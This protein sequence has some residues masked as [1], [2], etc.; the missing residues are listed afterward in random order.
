MNLIKILNFHCYSNVSQQLW[1]TNLT[2]I[3]PDGHFES[4]YE[5]NEKYKMLMPFYDS[6]DWKYLIRLGLRTWVNIINGEM[7]KVDR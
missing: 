5:K 7:I 4:K 2:L 1:F 6:Y 3:A